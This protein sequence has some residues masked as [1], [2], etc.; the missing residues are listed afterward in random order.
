MGVEIH[1]SLAIG[2]EGLNL[3]R[4]AWWATPMDG[5]CLSTHRAGG[6]LIDRL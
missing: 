3:A 2:T 4:A 6:S 1:C 5:W